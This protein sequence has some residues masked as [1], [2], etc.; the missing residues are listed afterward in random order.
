[1]VET[2]SIPLSNPIQPPL[3]RLARTWFKLGTWDLGFRVSGVGVY[4]YAQSAQT[5]PAQEGAEI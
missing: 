5:G 4:D 1:M 2:P 3:T